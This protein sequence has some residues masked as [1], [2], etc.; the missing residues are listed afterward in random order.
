MSDRAPTPRRVF[1]GYVT[2]A[3]LVVVALIVMAYQ[4]RHDAAVVSPLTPQDGDGVDTLREEVACPLPEGREGEERE[5]VIADPQVIP[6]ITSN[7]L[8][9]C[10][11]TWDG[12]K[13]RYTGEV[14]G[15]L[16]DR[17]DG[18]WTQLNDDAYGLD[19]APLPTHSDFRGGNAGI[20]V[21]LSPDTAARVRWVGGP[22][23]QGDVLEVVGRFQRIDNA[24]GEVAVIRAEEA[25]LVSEGRATEVPVP[26]ARPIVAGIAAVAA[27]GMTVLERRTRTR[28]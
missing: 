16:L 3:A 13:V 22:G 8:Y 18:V 27:L 7:D 6:Q 19:Q 28:R 15:A 4:L 26:T 21:L 23:R 24:T 2:V 10:P 14:V 25:R 1:T 20:G 9:D 5:A 11:Q 17:Q 12:R